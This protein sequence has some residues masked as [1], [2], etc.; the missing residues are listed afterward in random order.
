MELKR[1]IADNSRDAL[2]QVKQH[3][4]ENALIISTNKIGKKT[5]VICAIEDSQGSTSSTKKETKSPH[6]RDETDNRHQ[7]AS[8]K[9]IEDYRQEI[10]NI[11]FSEQ[12]GRI[13]S[14]SE[15]KAT[16]KAP[17]INE[18]MKTIQADLSDLRNKLET[19]A[20]TVTPITKARSALKAFGKREKLIDRQNQISDTIGKLLDKNLSE[21]RSWRGINVFY[22]MPGSGKTRIIE[23]ILSGLSEDDALSDC[24]L[25][26]LNSNKADNLQS[27][28]NLA[29][30]GNHF[31]I[32]SFSENNLNDF[33]ARLKRLVNPGHVFI[34]VCCQDLTETRKITSKV[35]ESEIKEYLCLSA[36]SAPS[37]MFQL[38]ES[39]PDLL[40]SIVLTRLD[41]VC[42]IDDMLSLL[43]ELS[44]SIAGVYSQTS[45]DDHASVDLKTETTSN[46]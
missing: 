37:S 38:V 18:L 4:G 36:D 40:Q 25:I 10:P 28:D 27:F 45:K 8:K 44:A 22:G 13:V 6:K 17:E 2:Q 42:D 32:A 14:K 3:H 29:K 35:N 34:E 31:N 20:N 12:L 41:L 21:Q 33:E 24:T 19:Q 15:P 16:S 1:F 5:E 26:Q 23:S 9:K 11:E 43:A 30:L 46:I 39:F 7:T